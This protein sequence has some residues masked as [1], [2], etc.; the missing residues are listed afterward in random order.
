MR[1]VPIALCA[2]LTGCGAPDPTPTAAASSELRADHHRDP[3]P[4]PMLYEKDARPFGR[5]V[6]HWS[7]QVWAYI[8]A[9]PFDHNPFLDTTG[10]DCAVGQAGPVWFLPAVPGSTLGT[11][12]TRSCAI[13]HQRA[14]IL[15]LASLMN[16]YPCPDPNFKPAPGQSLY[17]FLMAPVTPAIDM[18]SGFQVWLDGVEIQ[19]VVGYRFT[20][21]RL[22]EF[23]GD[24][25]MQQ[26]FDVC[27][28][29]KRQPAVSD[30][31]YLMF[32]PMAPGP[33]TILVHG[34]DMEGTKVTLTENLTIE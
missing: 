1:L 28:T 33:H 8:Y 12:V 19:D 9:Q 10:A 22:F 3:N 6:T 13:P 30:G 32:K 31:I 23:T 34:Q 7:E 11:E 20:S 27:V 15:Q 18:V 5:T 4:N 14:I 21:P 26:N 2:V 24:L 16:D 25:S 17:D 29:G